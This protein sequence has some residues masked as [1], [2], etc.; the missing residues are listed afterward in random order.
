MDVDTYCR[1]AEREEL[2]RERLARAV[3][4]QDDGSPLVSLKGSGLPL[5]FEPSMIDGYDYRVREAIY[6]KIARI[7]LRLKTQHKVLII[8]SAW[9]SFD[10][11]TRLWQDKVAVMRKDHPTQDQDEIDEIVSRF[12]AP[13]E[14]SMHAT[15]GAVD[16]LIYDHRA[17]RVLDFGNNEGLKLE[18][19]ETCY[20]DHP[21]I[22]EPARR[23][24]RL[25]MGLFE[26]EGFVVDCIEY[27]HFDYGNASWAAATGSRVAQF[28]I[29]K[30]LTD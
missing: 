24:R 9:R 15:G 10:H 7:S 19:D 22:A 3:T 21:G 5:M 16:A 25:L 27:W 13:P 1:T 8:R 30:S 23:N 12:V 2:D 28:G 29:V 18:L 11:Q 17:R 14:E 26:E 4:V 6:A 20:P